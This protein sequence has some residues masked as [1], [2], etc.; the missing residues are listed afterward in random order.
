LPPKPPVSCRDA[1]YAAIVK[2]SN[3]RRLEFR[4][5][6]QYYQFLDLGKAHADD[7]EQGQRYKDLLNS[8]AKTC[9]AEMRFDSANY[10]LLV[11]GLWLHRGF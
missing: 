9:S 11:L 5:K 8:V 3:T 1:A 2:I 6:L 4:I 10:G 7:P